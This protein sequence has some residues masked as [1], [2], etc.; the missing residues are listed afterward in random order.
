MAKFKVGDKFL[1]FRENYRVFFDETGIGL[2]ISLPFSIFGIKSL[3]SFA[4]YCLDGYNIVLEHP[5]NWR[6]S[7]AFLSQE[8]AITLKKIIFPY[9]SIVRVLYG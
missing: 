8:M 1:I 9:N 5:K 6:H 4:S 2:D 7:P 3:D